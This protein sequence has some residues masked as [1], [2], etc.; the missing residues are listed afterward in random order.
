MTNQ[1]HLY[2][3]EQVV[4]VITSCGIEK[5]T[6]KKVTINV[7]QVD[8]TTIFYDI[9]IDGVSDTSAHFEADTFGTKA[10][11][12]SEYETRVAD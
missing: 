6:V 8:G 3:P 10:D 2:D 11:A 1:T 7:T 4:W 12:I 5:A 9:K